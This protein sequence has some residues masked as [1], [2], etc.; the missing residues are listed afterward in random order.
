MIA[1]SSVPELID[2]VKS[3]ANLLPVGARTKSRLSES[4]GTTLIDLRKLS[5]I[6]EYQPSEYTFTAGA[7]TT[8]EEVNQALS[9]KGQYLPFDP[10]FISAGAT[11]G[12]TIASNL[13]GP[14]RFRFG[15]LRDFILGL[16]YVD[17]RGE[18]LKGGGKVVKNAAGFDLPKLMVGSLGRL[19][20]MTEV[21]FKVFPRPPAT[22]TLSLTFESHGQALSQLSALANSRYE[23]DALDY[24]PSERTLL[25]RLAGPDDSNT[26]LAREI[27]GTIVPCDTVWPDI[28][29]FSW[30]PANHA[31]VKVPT[32]PRTV[33]AFLE[34]LD[35][36]SSLHTHLSAGAN[37]LWI[38]TPDIASLDFFFSEHQI[39]GQVIRGSSP[40]IHLG[41]S[42][43]PEITRSLKSVFDPDGRFAPAD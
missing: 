27:G 35:Q 20:I 9:A 16:T 26:A 31:L 41:P 4:A 22:L 6:T 33:E 23:V 8:L 32:T 34:S 19:G 5:G 2:A 40:K 39:P 21:T 28:N 43:A 1:P 18:L 29:R 12:G 25:I 13:S 38:A 14:G 15:G 36:L 42:P 3:T 30:A 10:P 17:G 11:L 7:G 37:L 24:R